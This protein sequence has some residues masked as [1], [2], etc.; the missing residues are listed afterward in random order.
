[1]KKKILVAAI[2]AAVAAPM[3][4]MADATVYGKVRVASQYHDRSGDENDAYGLQD[5]ISRLGIK[6]SEDLG[7]GLKAIYKME[8]GVNV[9]DGF[10]K[11]SFWSQRNA[12]VGLAGGWGTLLAGKHDTPHK[13]ST[14]KLDLFADT[15]A[16]HDNGGVINPINPRGVG[17]FIKRRTD[18]TIAYISPNFSGFQLSG[19]LVQSTTTG[20]TSTDNF[21]DAYSIAGTYSNGPWYAAAAYETLQDDINVGTE[22]DSVWTIGLGMLDYNGFSLAGIYEDRSNR[23]GLDDADNKSWQISAGY[24]FGNNMVKGMYGQFDDDRRIEAEEQDN[25]SWAIGLQHNFSKRTDVQV[26]YRARDNDNA[27]NDNVFAL[28]MDHAF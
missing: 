5:Q 21:L 18:G 25:T 12:Y 1:M 26:L 11:S 7:N 27:S 24:S 17:L 22:D 10:G 4:V 8:F 28:Q 9:G 13:M 16:D 2:A 19:A 23:G 15:A 6:G 20:A 3:A 14:G